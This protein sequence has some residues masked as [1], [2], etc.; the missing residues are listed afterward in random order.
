MNIDYALV[1][2]S[3]L[4]TKVRESDNY[5]SLDKTQWLDL[6]EYS[7]DL[8]T[9]DPNQKILFL[10]CARG[11]SEQEEADRLREQKEQEEAQALS[12]ALAAQDSMEQDAEAQRKLDAERKAALRQ[13]SKSIFNSLYGR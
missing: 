10:I 8:A 9:D 1:T 2:S 3:S 12:D 6:V 7:S 4:P 13:R 5:V 11:T